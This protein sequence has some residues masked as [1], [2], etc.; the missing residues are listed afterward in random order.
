MLPPRRQPL[1][2]LGLSPRPAPAQA[3]ARTGCNGDLGQAADDAVALGQLVLQMHRHLARRGE[4]AAE[5]LVD[6]AHGVLKAANRALGDFGGGDQFPNR[7]LERMLVGL[8]PL[9]ALVEQDA[10]AD[11]DHQ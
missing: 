7:G 3:P 4:L 10:I 11:R 8:Q 6:V 5:M 1:S 2:P 9:Q